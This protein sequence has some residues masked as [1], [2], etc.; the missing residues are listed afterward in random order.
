MS[1]FIWIW[2]YNCHLTIKFL[3]LIKGFHKSIINSLNIFS[4]STCS[5]FKIIFLFLEYLFK[6]FEFI[7]FSFLPYFSFCTNFWINLQSLFFLLKLFGKLLMNLHLCIHIFLSFF[8]WSFLDFFL[9]FNMLLLLFFFF[10]DVIMMR[11][12]AGGGVLMSIVAW[13]RPDVLRIFN[14]VFFLFFVFSHFIYKLINA[15]ELS[16]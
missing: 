7:S 3:Y 2:F 9:L 1:E 10:L 11:M 6:F 14:V 4:A 16:L 5:V 12:A 15:K 8:F 13:L